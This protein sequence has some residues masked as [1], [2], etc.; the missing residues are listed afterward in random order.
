GAAGAGD[1]L[2]ALERVGE[3][4]LRLKEI[5]GM[6][7][8]ATLNAARRQEHGKGPARRLRRAG[9]VPAVIYGHGE[10]TRSL[11]ID[12]HELERLFANIRVE[13]TII[14]LNIDGESG[15]PVRA[16]VR[17]VQM[18]P[19]RS[20]VLHVDFLQVH[21]GERVHLEVPVRL[22]GT[23]AGVREGGILQQSLH[24]VE[25]QC[26]PDQIPESFE[27]DVSELEVGDSVHVSD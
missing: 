17:E 22:T 2:H 4:A 15:A 23:A 16:L 13:S 24:E 18:H 20:E 12:A 27:F 8:T 26:L 14:T 19:Y 5:L 9:Q 3:S 1:P 10:R 6:V 7:T 25:I 21:A 11:A